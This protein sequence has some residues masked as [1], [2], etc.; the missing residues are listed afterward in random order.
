MIHFLLYGVCQGSVLGPILFYIYILHIGKI[1]CRHGFLCHVYADD[2]QV[3]IGFKPEDAGFVLHK[4]D[5]C[6]NEIHSW[7][8]GHK[9]KINDDKTEFMII[10]SKHM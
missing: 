1:V 5:L 9:L 7:M 8:T 3:Y 2:T 10:S 6:I 4:L